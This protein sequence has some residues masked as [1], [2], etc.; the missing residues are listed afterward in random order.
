M[1]MAEVRELAELKKEA[2]FLARDLQRGLTLIPGKE[3]GEEVGK[4]EKNLPKLDQILY[5]HASNISRSNKGSCV[6]VSEK[7]L[8]QQIRNMNLLCIL[9]ERTRRDERVVV[10]ERI[11]CH[12]RKQ[13]LAGL[14]G[15]LAH[16]V[17]TNNRVPSLDFAI[18]VL[19]ARVGTN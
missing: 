9:N 15:K 19:C 13:R 10:F 11:S 16:T 2:I 5:P 17:D 3:Q 12:S 14:P 6:I 1:E 8:H 18:V 4:M 7:F